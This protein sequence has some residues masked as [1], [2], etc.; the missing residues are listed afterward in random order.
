MKTGHFEE[1]I[2]LGVVQTA[3]GRDE[4]TQREL[5]TF[6]ND[7]GGEWLVPPA[8]CGNWPSNRETWGGTLFTQVDFAA[9]EVL[10]LPQE[11]GSHLRCGFNGLQIT[12]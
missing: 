3:Q 11:P 12:N 9:I 7:F 4:S 8:D 5:T 2:A 6:H 1:R 10:H